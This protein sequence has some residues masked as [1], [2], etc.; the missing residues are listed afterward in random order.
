MPRISQ[1]FFVFAALCGTFGMGWGIYMG[2]SQDHSTFTAHA[3]L[4][5]LGWVSAA[6]MGGF[7]TLAKDRISGPL[8]WVNFGLLSFGIVIMIPALACK[9]SGMHAGWIDAGLGIGSIS[10]FLGMAT[11][12]AAVLLAV[13]WPVKVA[14]QKLQLHPA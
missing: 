6:L 4:N 1:T 9:V 11:F 2:L 14:A 3:H 10:A 12:A 5:L 8:P 7:Y 13:F